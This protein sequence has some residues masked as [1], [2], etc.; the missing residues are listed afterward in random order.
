MPYSIADI[1]DTMLLIMA[2]VAGALLA[3]VLPI[4]GYPLCAASLGGL[5]FRDRMLAAVLAAASAA[6]VAGLLRPGDAIAV[7]IA[8]T[9][10]LYAARALRT[11]DV[12]LIA[13]A[14]LPALAVG[15]MGAELLTARLQGLTFAGYM[16]E[17]AKQTAAALGTSNNVGGVTVAQLADTMT[18][19]A[20]AAYVMLAAATLVPTLATLVWS[21][22]RSGVAVQTVVPLG[23]LDLSPHA[24][25]PLL[26]AVC[27]MAAGRLWGGGDAVLTTIGTN[28]ILIARIAL[29]LQGLAVVVALTRGGA[30]RAGVIAIVALALVIDMA[31][32]IVSLLGLADFWL[33]FRRLDRGTGAPRA[34][35]SAQGS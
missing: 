31:T 9:A 26:A 4:A 24:L 20:P 3:P 30:G 12:Y 27:F 15:F 6:A 29:L 23:E 33:N 2:C 7:G 5:Y 18:R 17:A 13:A 21:A 8:M 1:R 11:R 25:W 14:M 32:W 19:F 35:E 28:L 34:G 22:R 10:L 16:M